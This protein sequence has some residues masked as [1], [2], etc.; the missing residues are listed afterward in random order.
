MESRDPIIL[1]A[2][3]FIARVWT[4]F[5]IAIVLYCDLMLPNIVEISDFL[6]CI[7]TGSKLFA[8]GRWSEMYAPYDA[9]KFAGTPCD[10]AAHQFLPHMPATLVSN[11]NY[12]PLVSAFF[13]PFT[14]L[15]PNFALLAWQ[16]VCAVALIFAVKFL[17]D[18]EER[19]SIFASTCLWFLPTAFTLWIGQFGIVFGVLFFAAGYHFLVRNRPFAAAAAFSLAC[20]KPQFVI[21]PGLLSLV[22]LLKREWKFPVGMIV[23]AVVIVGLNLVIGVEL[24]RHW[25]WMMRLSEM[26]FTDPASGLPRHLL[27]SLPGWILLMMSPE[28][29]HAFKPFVYGATILVACLCGY[30]GWKADK[31]VWISYT[32]ILGIMLLPLL[33]PHYMYYDLTTL[34]VAFWLCR[35]WRFTAILGATINIYG[36]LF[37]MRV[38][39]NPLPV[40]AIMIGVFCWFAYAWIKGAPVERPYGS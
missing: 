3:I 7:Y 20:L 21:V 18:E 8:L 19:Q 12:C 33:I 15:P 35:D 36:L 2:L 14:Y 22:F 28:N 6:T 37:F 11:Y 5:F 25:I 32:M 1:R 16:V 13:A 9:T 24:F 26:V 39:V 38:P 17:V 4:I 40:L 29:A 10:I 27:I 30:L 31:E 23:G 34:M